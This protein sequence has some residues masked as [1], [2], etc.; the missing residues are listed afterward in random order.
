V[1]IVVSRRSISEFE[2][3]GVVVVAALNNLSELWAGGG[4]SRESRGLLLV[5]A[6]LL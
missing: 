6:F 4:R 1:L 3:L 2:D 5:L